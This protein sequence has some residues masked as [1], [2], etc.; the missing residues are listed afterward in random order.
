MSQRPSEE[1]SERNAFRVA[2]LRCNLLNTFIRCLQEVDCAFDTQAL[3][4]GQRC[5]SEGQLKSAGEGPLAGA[6]GSSGRVQGKAL[7]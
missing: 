7:R 2:Y 4:I 5:F 6:D 1:R 3:E